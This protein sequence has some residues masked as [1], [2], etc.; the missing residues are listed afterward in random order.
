MNLRSL[1]DN[2]KIKLKESDLTLNEFSL[3]AD[4]SEDTLRSLIY[5]DAKD[6]KLSTLIKIADA[7]HC[8]IDT[9]L[10]R[11]VYSRQED[12]LI[13][14]LQKLSERSIHTVQTLIQLE[15]ISHLT[16]SNT[17]RDT[18]QIFLPTG[19]M[20]DGYFYDN[21]LFEAL[22]ITEYPYSLKNAVDFGIKILSTC[23]EP[24]YCLNDILLF[25]QKHPPQYNDIVL[26]TDS[27]GHIY[28]RKYTAAGLMPV[29]NFGTSISLNEMHN[30]TAVGVALKVL[31]EFNIEQFR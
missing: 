5:G 22:D 30:Y 13:Q 20:K 31:K 17:G 12:E 23:Y 15:E 8:S 26:Y 19:N 21:T 14:R 27:E 10:S 28:I 25:S 1:R 6:I 16:V 24:Y 3:H 29:N 4:L 18:I 7:F 2:L 11:S 9:I